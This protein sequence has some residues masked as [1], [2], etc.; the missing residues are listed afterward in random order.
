MM[1]TKRPVAVARSCRRRRQR[2]RG[3]IHRRHHHRGRG[4]HGNCPR[5]H[6]HRRRH[7]DGH[8]FGNRLDGLC[9]HHH[10]R[11][12]SGYHG[13]SGC[14]DFH[15]FRRRVFGS[16][17]HHH[18]RRRH[19]LDDDLCRLDLS[20]HRLRLSHRQAH[21]N[22]RSDRRRRCHRFRT[23]RGR[24]GLFVSEVSQRDFRGLGDHDGDDDDS[25]RALATFRM[26]RR[27]RVGGCT[28]R[29]PHGWGHDNEDTMEMEKEH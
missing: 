2:R 29:L 8:R 25:L 27:R 17:H 26:G 13:T 24:V 6:E 22:G 20:S 11:N 7:D 15:R 12:S 4:D 18:H 10:R 16:R 9:R 1:T 21:R 14:R 19:F 23:G 28:L 3:G 5:R